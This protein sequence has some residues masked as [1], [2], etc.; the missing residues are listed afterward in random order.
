MERLHVEP[1]SSGDLKAQ[2]F[3]LRSTH[4]V[5]EDGQAGIAGETP[6]VLFAIL[7]IILG[8]ALS[9]DSLVACVRRRTP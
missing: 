8:S 1:S 2:R 7:I 6:L 3:P 9:S 4:P 5:L